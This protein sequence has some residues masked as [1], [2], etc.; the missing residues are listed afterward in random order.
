LIRQE[1]EFYHKYHL[2][3]PR[4][5][6]DQRHLERTKLRNPKKLRDRTCNNCWITIKTSYS[7]DRP[8]KVYCEQCYNHEV[9]W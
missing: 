6:P 4:K 7:P 9:Y 5:H 2:P 8:E 1:L 3:L